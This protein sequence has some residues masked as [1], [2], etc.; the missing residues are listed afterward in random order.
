M[1]LIVTNDLVMGK[2]NQFD[3]AI[4]L[5]W[6]TLGKSGLFISFLKKV[7]DSV[8]RSLNLL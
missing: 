6:L 2:I 7:D 1:L 3:K 4:F 5:F 8:I